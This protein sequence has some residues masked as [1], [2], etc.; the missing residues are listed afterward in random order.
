MQRTFWLVLWMGLLPFQAL[1][2]GDCLR[3][4]SPNGSKGIILLGKNVSRAL[5][6]RGICNT[7]D[8]K[9]SKRATHDLVHGRYD[10]E[11]GRIQFYNDQVHGTA[12]PVHEALHS[13]PGMLTFKTDKNFSALSELNHKGIKVGILRGWVWMEKLTALFP[14]AEIF[15]ASDLKNLAHMLENGRIDAAF[16]TP[17]AL[18]YLNLSKGYNSLKVSDIKLYLWLHF[19]Q[20][21]QEK[22]IAEALS[23][24]HKI[25]KSFFSKDF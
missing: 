22:R 2:H 6:E 21:D 20:K 10:G 14:N 18:K 17:S 15:P 16:F 5:N 12:I 11:I 8:F 24:Y 23:F 13:Y 19:T 1:A 3:F 4:V 7:V 9:P 25:G